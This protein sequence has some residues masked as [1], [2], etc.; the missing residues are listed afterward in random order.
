MPQPT[1]NS[2]LDQMLKQGGLGS[3]NIPVDQRFSGT[4][5]GTVNIGG[6]GFGGGGGGGISTNVY[7]TLTPQQHRI[8]NTLEGNIAAGSTA[9]TGQMNKAYD[10]ALSANPAASLNAEATAKYIKD[11]VATPLLRQYDQ[12]ILPRLNDAYASVGALMG[13]RRGFANQQALQ[14]L[15][16]QI[17][18]QLGSAQ[19]ANMHQGAALQ[20][21]TANRQAIVG[22]QLGNQQL[23]YNQLASQLTGQPWMAIQPYTNG[24]GMG[25]FG[26]GMG[27]VPQQFGGGFS[28]PNWGNG[29]GQTGGFTGGGVTNGGPIGSGG[30]P[31]NAGDGPMGY[32]Q[33]FVDAMNAGL[34]GGGGGVTTTAGGYSNMPTGIYGNDNG[35]GQ[36]ADQWTQYGYE[37]YDPMN[38][39][40]DVFGE[41]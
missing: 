7:D 34:G 8:A 30:N 2:W 17:A 23:G 15:Q 19:L 9:R 24:G 16:G 10:N 35:Y 40:N 4:G 12:T 22:N 6:G 21:E 11:S 36:S 1:G 5:G 33:E 3:Q 26:G 28:P 25:G 27:G 38:A 29:W 32:P 39:W 37:P 13:S 31:M 41:L 18:Q 14:N 20:N